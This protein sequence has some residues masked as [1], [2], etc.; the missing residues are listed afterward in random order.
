[1]P[2]SGWRL[3]ALKGGEWSRVHSVQRP[4]RLSDASAASLRQEALFFWQDTPVAR[5]LDTTPLSAMAAS[6]FPLRSFPL[7]H[8][9]PGATAWAV[10]TSTGW[11]VY[12]GD[13]RFHGAKGGL[14]R[15]FI[16]Q[17]SALRPRA[18]V[19]EGTYVES[20]RLPVT[21]EEVY[22][23]SL[24]AA[25]GA[26]GLIIAD[27]APRDIERLLTF[28]Q[29]AQEIGRRLVV[30]PRDAYLLEATALMGSQVSPLATDDI[31]RVFEDTKTGPDKWEKGVF[32]R[33]RGQ[34][35]SAEEISLRQTDYM[36]CFSFFDLNKLPSI[37]PQEGSVY[38]YSSSEPHDE[39]GGLDMRRLNQWIRRFGM[40]PVGVP[41]W[42][43]H[44]SACPLGLR[45]G[46]GHWAVPDEERGLHASG[47]ATGPQLLDMVK[48]IRP[49]T[50]I[51]V[52]SQAPEHYL[53]LLKGTGVEVHLP[54]QG[55]VL[56]L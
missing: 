18:L 31:F 24:R 7:D 6:P 22:E 16:E 20:E 5:P 13:I 23:N 2:K 27:F 41:Q 9:I 40:R 26:R 12:T 28:R 29:V 55:G 39:E 10:E 53:E 1:V 46:C 36:V 19:A 4:F 42:T 43:E 15:S 48:S 34:M 56:A 33:H 52:H 25:S 38:I 11:V 44:A 50:F 45:D 49:Q 21:E 54:S 35:V 51:P 17:A 14:S 32:E 3:G 8:S 47:H 30:L 37:M